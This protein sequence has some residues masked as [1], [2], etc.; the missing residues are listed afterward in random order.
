L[1]EKL[2]GGIVPGKEKVRNQSCQASEN[3]LEDR[4]RTQQGGEKKEVDKT[5]K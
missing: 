4:L 3:D 5:L 2:Q 1:L